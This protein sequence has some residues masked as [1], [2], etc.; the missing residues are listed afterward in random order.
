MLERSWIERSPEQARL[1]NPAFVGVMLWSC[2]Q[3]YASVHERRLPY[4]LTFIAVPIALHKVTREALPKSIRTSMLSWLQN[5]PRALVGFADRASVL[6]PL[7]KEGIL[8][9]SHCRMLRFDGT[10]L[11]AADRPRS[12]TRFEREATNEVK[13]CFRKANFIG[14][15]LAGSGDYTTAMAHWGVAP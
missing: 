13:D 7:V 3:G 12:L 15:W 9:A 2:A 1:F 10:R 11:A 4:A 14:K 6:V 5:N 8:F